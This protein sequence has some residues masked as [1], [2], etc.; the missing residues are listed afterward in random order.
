MNYMSQIPTHAGDRNAI[1][2]DLLDLLWTEDV[3]G[4]RSRVLSSQQD[5]HATIAIGGKEIV[6]RLQPDHWRGGWRPSGIE[7]A[8]TC[9]TLDPSELLWLVLNALPELDLLVLDRTMRQLGQSE[10]NVDLVQAM[11]TVLSNAGKQPGALGNDLLWERMA[12]WRDRPFHPLAHSRGCWG[13]GEIQEYGAEFGRYFPLRWCAVEKSNLFASPRAKGGGPAAA[14][15]DDA[16]SALLGQELV[17]LGIDTTH[18]ALPLHPWQADHVAPREFS[19]ELAD[20]RITM[21]DFRG[22]LVVAT[23][24]L[25]TVAIPGK[26]GC[27]LKL[28]LDVETLGVRRLLSAQSLYN[29]LK[30]ADVL[31]S[32]LANRPGLGQI[33]RLADETQFWTFS[34]LSGDVLAPRTAYLGCA[35]RTFPLIDGASLIPLAAFAVAP[36]GG[37]PPAIEASLQACRDNT[38]EGFIVELFDLLAGFA[39]EALASGF[40]PEMHGQNVLVEISK[41]RPSAVILRDH[42]TVR[43]HTAGLAACGL[44]APEYIIKDP[45]RAT[46]LLSRPEDLIAYGQTLLFDVALRAICTELDRA[47]ALELS[48]SRHL[49]RTSVEHRLECI[50]MPSE[51]RERLRFALLEQP[52]WPFKQIL[53]PLLQTTELGL[54]MPSRLGLASNPLFDFERNR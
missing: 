41:G 47:G 5:N 33:A 1:L 19:E 38:L 32:A 7:H 50:E 52:D 15:L 37:I 31:A 29:G 4:L 16:Q 53:T 24:S 12:A 54:G 11:G 6:V 46:M 21:L 43:C 44:Q 3:A 48:T 35:V 2:D 18:E 26:P 10:K 45:R 8:Q 51:E 49:L 23:S 14:I 34:E 27:H 42:D 17:R 13:A 20:G 39:I 30:G 40:I 22:P 9:K 25:R 36:A 28:P